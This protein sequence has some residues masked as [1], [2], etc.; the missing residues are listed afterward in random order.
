MPHTTYPRDLV[1]YGRNPPDP[2]WP[3]EARICVQ[4]V[5]NYEEGGENNILHGDRASEAFLSEIVGAQAWPGQ[6][7]MNMES[8]YEYG[9][10]A[11][12]WRLWRL[13]TER[14]MPVTVFGVATAMQRH[15]EAVA[16]MREAGWEIASHGLKWIDYKDFTS[17]EERAHIAEAVRIHTEVAGE[18]P[19]GFYQGR[20]SE[21]TLRLTME[22]GGFLY[23]ADSYADELPYWVEGPKGPQL[24]VPYTLDANDMRFATPQGFNAGDQ[25]FAYLKDSFDVLYAEGERAPKMM[26]VGLHCR[27][28][29]RPGRAA[30]LARFLDYVN[31][32]EDVWVARRIDIARHWIRQHRP[33]G[34][35]P[36]R[37]SRTL[38]VE[39]F[40][41][42]FEHSPWIAETAYAN[43]LTTAQDVAEGLHAA[44]VPVLGNGTREQK[45]ALIRAHPDLAGRLKLADLTAD[46]QNEQASAGLDSLTPE[47]RDFFL[48]IND[49]YKAKF[50]FPFIMAVKGRTKDEIL[51]AFE[52]RLEHDPEQEFDAALVQIELIALLRLKDRLPSMAHMFSTMA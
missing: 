14:D 47:E 6:R 19:L 23:S 42:V 21:H 12:F 1:G 52:E 49:R 29:G 45:L 25:F 46:S 7:H 44:M 13:F 4:F 24:V 9:S 34:L 32:H 26:S 38:F 17:D 36:S 10:R 50:G 40:G 48:A 15:P 35:T 16:A 5:V 27:L 31:S 20:T 8:I 22:E 18:R 30:A 39:L 33:A 11:G 37:M 28:V 41:D 2:R 3:N 51:A 43:G